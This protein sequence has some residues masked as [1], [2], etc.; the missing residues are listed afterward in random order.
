MSAVKCGT[1][2][3]HCNSAVT[4]QP[5]RCRACRAAWASSTAWAAHTRATRCALKQIRN[6]ARRCLATARAARHGIPCASMRS[7]SHSEC[8]RKTFPRECAAL[9]CTALRCAALHGTALRC[10]AL[11]CT[12]LRVT[13]CGRDR[14][15]CEGTT[16]PIHRRSNEVVRYSILSTLQGFPPYAVLPTAITPTQRCLPACR[17]LH[18]GQ[19]AAHAIG[20]AQEHCRPTDRSAHVPKVL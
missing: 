8:G 9:R 15:Q 7:R 6:G 14:R 19:R 18:C 1:V 12:T 3:G 17:I 11:H 5:N 13:T 10:T 16:A 20:F 2:N 4:A